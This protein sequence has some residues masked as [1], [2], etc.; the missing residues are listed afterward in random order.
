MGTSCRL[1]G[2]GRR[3]GQP[4]QPEAKKTGGWRGQSVE[5]WASR[6]A[7]GLFFTL[8][9]SA[10]RAQQQLRED[11]GRKDRELLRGS[12]PS[13]HSKGVQS[14]TLAQSCWTPGAMPLLPIHSVGLH[15]CLP[16][17]PGSS[18]PASVPYS[19]WRV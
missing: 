4:C 11:W 1:G 5:H 15:T 17:L 8:R 19:L 2:R 18:P 3:H 7:D 13:S 9:V 12:L 6:Q 14:W 10:P 16:A